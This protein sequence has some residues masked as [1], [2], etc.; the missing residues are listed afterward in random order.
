[1]NPLHNLAESLYSEI[2]PLFF[3]PYLIAVFETGATSSPQ[4]AFQ[5]RVPCKWLSLGASQEVKPILFEP[6]R[7][8]SE[9]KWGEYS[10]TLNA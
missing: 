10:S 5:R 6:S 4:L 2:F 3:G 7:K 9:G 1:M 8:E